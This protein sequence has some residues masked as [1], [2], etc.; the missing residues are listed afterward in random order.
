MALC[1]SSPHPPR[2]SSARFYTASVGT[3]R[4]IGLRLNVC[5]QAAVQC[6]LMAHLR[7]LE[8]IVRRGR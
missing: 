1:A 6:P 8:R 3:G 2:R 4:L 7:C 5:F